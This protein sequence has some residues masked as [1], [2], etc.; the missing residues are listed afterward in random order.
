MANT[1]GPRPQARQFL[2]STI[3]SILLYGAE[4]GADAMRVQEY[5]HG[6]EVI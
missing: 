4:V 3:H 5:R 1:H 6:M 2:M